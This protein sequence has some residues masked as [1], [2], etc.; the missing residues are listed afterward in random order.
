MGRFQIMILEIAG[1]IIISQIVR[2][3]LEKMYDVEQGLFLTL[4]PI[5]AALLIVYAVRFRIRKKILS[6]K[7]TKN[8][9]NKPEN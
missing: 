1:L 6:N 8:D 4:F 3:V 9:D 5:G 2:Y 7:S